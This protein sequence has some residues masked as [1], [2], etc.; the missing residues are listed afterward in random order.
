M[1]AMLRPNHPALSTLSTALVL[2]LAATTL[3]ACGNMTRLSEIGQG[4]RL[5]RIEDPQANPDYKPVSFPA[6]APQPAERNPNSLWRNGAR[7][8]FKDQRASQV[9]DLLTVTVSVAD[10]ADLANKSARSRDNSEADSATIP[11]TLG[12]V[13][14]TMGLDTGVALTNKSAYTGTG[15]VNRSEALSLTLAAV[16]IQTLPNGNLV[17]EGKQQIRV[18]AELRE[19][20]L[21]GIIRREDITSANTISSDKIAEARISYGGRGF[22]GDVQSPRYGQELLDILAPF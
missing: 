7:A 9:G 21:R 3:S 5:D 6:P 22:S 20:T 1:T 11:G 19:L 10:K 15:A 14:S 12:R 2:A 18:N 4:P 16:V 17:I 8:F 13:A